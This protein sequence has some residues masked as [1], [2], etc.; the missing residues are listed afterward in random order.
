MINVLILFKSNFEFV[1]VL[2]LIKMQNIHSNATFAKNHDKYSLMSCSH[3]Q[4]SPIVVF[5]M[6]LPFLDLMS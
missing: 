4:I 3:S 6:I 5:A 2:N 1:K